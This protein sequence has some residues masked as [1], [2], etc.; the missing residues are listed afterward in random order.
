MHQG[1]TKR[2]HAPTP[3]IPARLNHMGLRFMTA[4]AGDEGGAPAAV[5]PS[6]LAAA[7]VSA[8]SVSIP[9]ATPQAPPTDTL[10]DD[11]AALKSII[12][13]LRKE[14][15]AA[16][17]NAKATAAQE[18]TDALT[19]QI[20]KALGLIK[21]G[22]TT[23]DPAT[24]TAQLAEQQ[25]TT[26]QSQRELAIFRTAATVPGADPTTLLDSRSFLEAV[27]DIAPTDQTALKAAIEKALTENPR[28]KTAQVANKSGGDLA[29]GTREGNTKTPK[30]LNDALAARY[31]N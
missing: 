3:G 4:P 8:D 11:A 28:L 14:N 27:K 13:D 22:D 15:G 12:A 18:A 6:D 20:G 31:G 1:T 24:L 10:P 25:A 9:P 7:A 2:F 30:S 23:P 19:Q 5:T 21:D 29:G 26:A 16:R 17:T